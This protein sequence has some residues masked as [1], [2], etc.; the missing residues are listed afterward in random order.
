[1]SS[2]VL[3]ASIL[4]LTAIP[5]ICDNFQKEVVLLREYLKNPNLEKEAVNALKHIKSELSKTLV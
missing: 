2:E 4:T 3:K 5:E 1:M